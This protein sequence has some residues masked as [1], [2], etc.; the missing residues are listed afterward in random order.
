MTRLSKVILVVALA[1]A[2][3]ATV[4]QVLLWREHRGV[5]PGHSHL[6]GLDVTRD[7]D[8][9]S[10]AASA[11]FLKVIATDPGM[12]GAFDHAVALEFNVPSS[13]VGPGKTFD[14]SE[15]GKVSFILRV[16]GVDYEVA[17]KRKERGR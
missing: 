6:S 2:L 14:T 9:P 4:M 7:V 17:A 10:G 5:Q 11:P 13:A 12:I 3:Y 1:V 16:N 8:P 15:R